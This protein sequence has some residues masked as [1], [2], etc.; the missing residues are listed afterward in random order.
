MPEKTIKRAKKTLQKKHRAFNKPT[1]K[2]FRNFTQ[3]L[4]LFV[5]WTSTGQYFHFL[6][7]FFALSPYKYSFAEVH[8][9]MHLNN[10][11]GPSMQRDGILS[12]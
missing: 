2:I 5:M 3:K 7:S 8:V 12:S 4:H 10:T 11:S 9:I 1:G 6:F